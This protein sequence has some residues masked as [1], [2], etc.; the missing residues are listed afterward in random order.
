M[1]TGDDGVQ[2][3]VNVAVTGAL[4]RANA[5]ASQAAEQGELSPSQLADHM[6]VL[7]R[8]RD[9]RARALDE[10]MLSFADG[11]TSIGMPVRC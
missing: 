3:A 7:C 5:L 10:G 8:W 9:E 1:L 2:T 11:S 4:K 6:Y